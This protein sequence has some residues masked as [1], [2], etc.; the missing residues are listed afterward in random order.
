MTE[1]RRKGTSLPGPHEYPG[2]IFVVAA[3]SGRANPSL[4]QLAADRCDSPPR[5]R[6]CL[7]TQRASAR[8]EQQGREYHSRRSRNFRYDDRSRRVLEWA[9]VRAPVR[10]VDAARFE[11]HITGRQD[12]VLETT[13]RREQI[14]SVPDAVLIFILPRAGENYCAPAPPRRRPAE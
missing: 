14:K 5:R 4:D 8:E 11:A 3:P 9:Q 2:N 6:R 12:V 7:A 1:A 13:G 10:H